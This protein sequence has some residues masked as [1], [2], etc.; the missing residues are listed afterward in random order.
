MKL[1]LILLFLILCSFCEAQTVPED[2]DTSTLQK[3]DQEHKATR[4]FVSDELTRQ[5]TEFFKEID[6]R[7]TY[8]ENT[9]ERLLSRT[10]LYLGLLWGGIVL[11]VV[12]V[13]QFLRLRLERNKFEKMLRVIREQISGRPVPVEN[14]A[15]TQQQQHIQGEFDVSGQ[16]LVKNKQTWAEKR[17]ARRLEKEKQRLERRRDKI[18]KT[19]PE[20]NYDFEVTY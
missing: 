15:Q 14:L 9:V 12:G 19:P 6:D 17:E 2:V 5:R 16:Q 11:L 1:K 10:I 13:T 4:K 7:A 3:I 8:Y 18:K 20:M